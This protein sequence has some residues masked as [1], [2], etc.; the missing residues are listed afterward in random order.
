MV[1]YINKIA[2]MIIF[3]TQF[4]YKFKKNTYIEYNISNIEYTNTDNTRKT[5]LIYD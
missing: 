3:A 5:T 2:V 4:K 1:C